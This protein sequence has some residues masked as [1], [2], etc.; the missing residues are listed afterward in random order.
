MDT[1]GLFGVSHWL[2]LASAHNGIAGAFPH[3]A[4][5]VLAGLAV[6]VDTNISPHEDKNISIT[7]NGKF[8]YFAKYQK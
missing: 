2:N 1:S 6:H 7:K 5:Q 3:R 8:H 4:L